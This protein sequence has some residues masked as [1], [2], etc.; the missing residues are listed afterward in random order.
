MLRD[1]YPERIRVRERHKNG[2]I[3]YH[4]IVVLP[5][6]IRTGFDFDGIS[7]R[8]YSSASAYLK[9]EWAF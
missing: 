1:R 4:L 5:E 6:D 3:H 9:A 2:A 8:D 7:K